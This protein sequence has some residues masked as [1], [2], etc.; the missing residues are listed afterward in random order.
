MNC[1]NK[2]AC[3]PGRVK[4]MYRIKNS[5]IAIV[6]HDNE[7]NKI[8]RVIPL[9]GLHMVSVAKGRNT[10]AVRIEISTRISVSTQEQAEILA[11][12]L[13]NYMYRGTEMNDWHRGPADDE[14]QA[15]ALIRQDAGEGGE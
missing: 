11:N 15:K 14:A 4:T 5:K 12:H 6:A 3:T 10:W 2:Q 13:A 1:L 8:A 7:G 9:N